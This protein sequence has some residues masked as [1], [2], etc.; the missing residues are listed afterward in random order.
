MAFLTAQWRDLLMINWKIPEQR[1]A[2]WVPKGCDVDTFQGNTYASLVAFQ[3]R[4][5][6]VLGV[7]VPGHRNFEEV[8]L[9]LYV[10]RETAEE[11]RRGVVFVREIVPRRLIAWVARTLYQEPYVA[12]PM[13]HRRHVTQDGRLELS[14]QW[15]N[16]QV[17]ATAGSEVRELV[18]GSEPQFI[19]EHYRGYTQLRSR[20]GS[21]TTREY[22]V[23]HPS[24]R[25]RSVENLNLHV[26]MG[27]LY[28]DEWSDLGQESPTSVFVAEGSDVEVDPWSKM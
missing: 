17:D 11:T 5:T 12:M 6:R 19:A 24:W 22:R 9:R 20:R 15:G 21:T 1:I 16:H 7:P 14:Y 23:S 26:D 13:S 27:A 4:N 8:N 10:K 2:S 25:W 28:G 18:D 3:F